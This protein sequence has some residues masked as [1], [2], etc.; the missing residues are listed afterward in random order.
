MV[1]LKTGKVAK[2]YG[3][4]FFESIE[5]SD[6][7]R[8]LEELKELKNLLLINDDFKNLIFH[9]VIPQDKKKEI[10]NDILKDFSFE[11]KNFLTLLIDEK[12]FDCIFDIYDYLE[13]RIDKKNNIVKLSVTLAIEA[14]EGI[15]SEIINKLKEKLKTDI[16]A[17]FKRDEQII[18][19][20]II[21][22]EDTVIDLSIKKKLEKF[23]Q[24]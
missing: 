24:I 22:I 13:K 19:G 3:E 5:N 17:E 23:R 18:G 4:A 8:F 1:D 10:L 16:K 12:R 11:I 15:K 6:Y 21:Q 2:R 14:G 7:N 20:M 9:P